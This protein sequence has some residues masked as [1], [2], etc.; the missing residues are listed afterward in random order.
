[1][2]EAR[3]ACEK[4]HSIYLEAYTSAHLLRC[5][6]TL[7]RHGSGSPDTDLAPA[8]RQDSRK[9]AKSAMTKAPH[10]E[11]AL[12]VSL[13]SLYGWSI[14]KA[15]C[16]LTTEASQSCRKFLV[17]C[18]AVL[19]ARVDLQELQTDLKLALKHAKTSFRSQS[20]AKGLLAF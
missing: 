4:G 10:S 11:L 17:V 5:G 13:T 8:N 20:L 2:A 15:C 6:R 14:A 3:F 12:T 19:M 18:L 9:L 7:V 16:R 1:M